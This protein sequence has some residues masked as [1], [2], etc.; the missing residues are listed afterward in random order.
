MHGL[1]LNV[2]TDLNYFDYIVPCGLT[3]KKVTSME[4]ILG[5]APDLNRVKS[6][7][8]RHLCDLFNMDPVQESIGKEPIHQIGRASCR[9]RVYVS[10]D[11]VALKNK[12]KKQHN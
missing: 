11:N 6:S 1:A 10:V 5:R 2:S 4:K 7:L 8:T 12:K 9:E 3:G